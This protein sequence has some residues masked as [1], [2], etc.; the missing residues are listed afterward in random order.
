MRCLEQNGA[1]C[2]LGEHMLRFEVDST[3]DSST[4]VVPASSV[5]AAVAEYLTLG[6]LAVRERST[7][8]QLKE[9]LVSK[10]SELAAGRPGIPTPQT[11]HHIRLRDGKV[12]AQ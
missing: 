7:V 9:L 6:D 4:E 10:W 11:V 3:S 8:G 5:S 12:R 1:G 2:Q